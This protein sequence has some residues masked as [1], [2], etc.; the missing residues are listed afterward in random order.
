MTEA[1]Q[2]AV[3]LNEAIVQYGQPLVR[4]IVHHVSSG[5]MDYWR[6]VLT[7]RHAEVV[8][9]IERTAGTVMVHTKAFYPPTPS[10]ASAYRLLSG[11]IRFDEDLVTALLRETHEETNLTV[12][13]VR[14]CG[15]L[16]HT[17]QLAAPHESGDWSPEDRLRFTSY[18][19]WVRPTGGELCCNDPD[20]SITGFR[21]VNL[22]EL[23]Q[24]AEALEN[25]P[26]G[27]AD[28]GRFR[29]GAHRFVVETLRGEL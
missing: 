5:T 20:E 1:I 25:L 11:G 27:W 6:K 22:E 16:R 13:I 18:L 26:A 9:L 23:E 19:F 17:L 7:R 10:D 3:G 28:W 15:I 2:D 14:F 29:A 24:L 4:Q 8:P 12:R 21:D